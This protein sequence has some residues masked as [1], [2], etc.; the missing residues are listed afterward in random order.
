[1]GGAQIVDVEYPASALG[2]PYPLNILA[3]RDAL[4]ADRLPSLISTNIG[5][6]QHDRAA[7]C[8]SALGVATAG[9]DLIKFGL[10]TLPLKAAQYQGDTIVRT[11]R[12]WF[13]DRKL[14]PAVF[15]D[16]DLLRYF[17][18]FAEGPALVEGIGA[19]GLLIDTFNKAAGQGLL[20]YCSLESVGALV[21]ELHSEGKEAWI[22]GSISLFELPSLWGLGVDVVCVRGAAC[23]PLEGSQRFGAVS[24]RLV[25]ELAATIPQ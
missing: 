8:Q 20:D 11:V 17:D 13:P 4:A 25:R 23:E 5:E 6:V 12:N 15:V 18:P 24:E 7:A 21:D 14:F 2:T 10:A 3:V 9:A 1:L 22:A 19:D 16:P